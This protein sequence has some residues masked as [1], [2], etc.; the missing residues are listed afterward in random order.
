MQLDTN[1]DRWYK[2]NLHTHTTRS[3]GA[4]TPEA[5][6]E[7]YKSRG[8]D[9]L[10][11]TD[12]WRLSETKMDDGLLLL[13]GCEYDTGRSVQEGIFHIVGIG[14]TEALRSPPGEKPPVQQLIDGVRGAGG[15][16]ILAHPAWSLNRPADV[17]GLTG[18]AG[19]EIYN[20]VSDRPWNA[21][22]YSGDFVDALAVA[23]RMLP[24]MAAD[25][26][27]F[28]N[29]DE[30]RSY[31]MV[32]AAQCTRDAIM[33]ALEAGDFYATQG[34]EFTVRRDGERLHVA[35]TPV[36][37]VVFFSDSVFA[38]DRVTRGDG[39]TAADYRISP[40]DTFVRVELHDAQGRMAWSSPIKLR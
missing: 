10:A 28:Y 37:D 27:H 12:H 17:L 14:M 35:C 15:I 1:G 16:A 31:L 32:R 39:V 25:D 3:D 40:T 38:A 22:P 23:G 2:G 19:V 36:R 4:N 34:P 33:T 11:L 13:S 9:F 7:L 20:T 24:C 26:T 8:Y 6:I 21:R 29:G 5:V 18:L 30:C